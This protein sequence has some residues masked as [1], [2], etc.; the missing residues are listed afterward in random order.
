MRRMLLSMIL[1]VATVVTVYAAPDVRVESWRHTADDWHSGTFV[2]TTVEDGVLR[3]LSGHSRGWYIA[4]PIESTDPFNAFIATWHAEVDHRQ[5]LTIEVRTSADG[6]SWGEWQ[7]LLPAAQQQQFVSNLLIAGPNQQWFQ[8]RVNFTA[9]FGS[10]ALDRLTLTALD[11]SDGLSSG[12]LVAE[13][14]ALPDAADQTPQ[15]IPYTAW[16]SFEPVVPSASHQP[17]QI[18]LVPIIV[19]SPAV[20]PPVVLRTLEWVARQH[21]GVTDLPYHLFLDADGRLYGG[22]AALTSRLPGVDS[23]IIRIGV[24]TDGNGNLHDVSQAQLAE[25]LDWLLSTYA[26]RL[27]NVGVASAAPTTF[28][29][30]VADIQAEIDGRVVRSQRIFAAGVDEASQWLSLFN[31]TTTDARATLTAYTAGGESQQTVDVPAGKRSELALDQLFPD[32]DVQSLGLQSNQLLHAERTISDGVN[33]LSS[34]GVAEPART[35]YFAHAS[36]M[37][38]TETLLAIFN[39]QMDQVAAQVVLYSDGNELVT[40]TVDLAPRSQTMLALGELLPDVTAGV[41]LMAAQPVVAEQE[42]YVSGGTVYL[43]AGSPVLER[44]W[45]FAEGVTLSGYTTTLHVFNPWPQR[46]GLT[47]QIMSEDGTSL[48]R[49]YAIPAQTQFT[50]PLNEIVPDLAFAFDIMAERPVAAERIVQLEEGMSAAATSGVPDLATRWTFTTGATLNTA[51]FLLVSNPQR[52]ATELEVL[53]ILA[54]GSTALQHY[55][56]PPTTRLTIWANEDVPDQPAITTV[57]IASQPVVAERTLIVTAPEGQRME[58]SLGE[59]GR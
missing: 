39:P 42:V 32:A 52:T 31:P 22:V 5:T 55:T 20:D 16:S 23:G 37:S 4:A 6:Q 41:Q 45:S 40:H 50:L 38:D 17:R 14:L 27:E 9:Q 29:D 47:L 44:R 59:P 7:T 25:L 13:P 21:W 34:S 53:Y 8:Y 46:V 57:I 11:A 1:V 48:M 49:R 28:R 35:W 10:P 54:D 43:S 19:A 58:T 15:A 12:E 26:L 30:A 33:L 3:L 56:I 51:Q 2:E 36:T 24:L 18:E